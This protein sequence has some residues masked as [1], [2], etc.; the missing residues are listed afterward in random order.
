MSRLSLDL[1]QK[2]LSPDLVER[3]DVLVELI[4]FG[5]REELVRCAVRRYVDRY[6]IPNSGLSRREAEDPGV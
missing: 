2:G 1:S 4:G 6:F 5:S 3:V